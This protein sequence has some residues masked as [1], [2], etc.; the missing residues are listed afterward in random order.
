MDDDTE[1][2][3]KALEIL[4]LD[5]PVVKAER[6]EGRLVLYLYG[7]GAVGLPL[8]ELGVHD[9]PLPIDE[10]LRLIAQDLAHRPV[11]ATRGGRRR[12]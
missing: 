9:E 10:T 11:R 5:V 4:R 2:I 1:L 7:G 3:A 8:S 6:R 12:A